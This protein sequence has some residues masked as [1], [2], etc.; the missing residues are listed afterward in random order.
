ML[1]EDRQHVAG[2]QRS[3]LKTT[4]GAPRCVARLPNAYIDSPATASTRARPGA[5]GRT[6]LT[7]LYATAV[8]IGTSRS[9]TVTRTRATQRDYPSS[10]HSS[11]GPTRSLERGIFGRVAHERVREAMH[12]HGPGHGHAARLESPLAPGPEPRSAVRMMRS[13]L[14]ARGLSRLASAGLIA[15]IRPDPRNELTRLR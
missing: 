10:S 12:V 8:C 4:H 15:R 11:S 3:T 5:A 2:S 13:S 14:I 7:G 9:S 1:W 6:S